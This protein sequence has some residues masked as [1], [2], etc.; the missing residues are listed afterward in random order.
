MTFSHGNSDVAKEPGKITPNGQDSVLNS[1]IERVTLRLRDS[2]QFD[3]AHVQEIQELMTS[4]RVTSTNSLLPI[5]LR[6][7]TTTQ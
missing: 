4:G 6:E 5:L 2:D 1:I 7:T 3:E